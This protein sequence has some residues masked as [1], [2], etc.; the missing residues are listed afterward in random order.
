MVID[1]GVWRQFLR[2]LQV[3]VANTV[4]TYLLYLL[5]ILVI[6]YVVAYSI[7]FVVGVLF[8]AWLNARHSFSTRLT[9]RTL[10]RF[11]VIYVINYALSVQLLVFCVEVIGMYSAI[12]LLAVLAVFTPINFLSSRLALTGHWR[13]QR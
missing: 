10:T 8:S 2:F 6:P 7:V 4:G 5:L 9:G 12:A 1:R 3:G 11:V 13:R